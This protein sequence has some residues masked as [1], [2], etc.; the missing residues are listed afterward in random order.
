MQPLQQTLVVLLLPSSTSFPVPTVN[1]VRSPFP[2]RTTLHVWLLALS[3]LS[4]GA[5][6]IKY[7]CIY[8]YIFLY[9]YIYIRFLENVFFDN[10]WLLNCKTYGF[11]F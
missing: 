4:L 3:D 9:L 1:L 2:E 6:G 11:H 8:I 10:L 7:I 5:N